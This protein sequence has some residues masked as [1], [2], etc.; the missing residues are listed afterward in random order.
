MNV[1]G[2]FVAEERL[3][4]KEWFSVSRFLKVNSLRRALCGKDAGRRMRE[5]DFGLEYVEENI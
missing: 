1:K 3:H 5:L 2:K 4:R